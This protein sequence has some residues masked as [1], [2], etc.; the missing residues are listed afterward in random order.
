M[1]TYHALRVTVGNREARA[2]DEDLCAF[3]VIEMA[4]DLSSVWGKVTCQKLVWDDLTGDCDLDEGY[5]YF[6]GC[7]PRE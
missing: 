2:T 6:D 4:Q 7:S 3:R 5:Y 1:T